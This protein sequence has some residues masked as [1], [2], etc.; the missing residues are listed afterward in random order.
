MLPVHLILC[1]IR[2][3]NTPLLYYGNP[4]K[5]VLGGERREERDEGSRVGL[6]LGLERLDGHPTVGVRHNFLGS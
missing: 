2:A 1:T 3:R 6:R 5:C 4:S